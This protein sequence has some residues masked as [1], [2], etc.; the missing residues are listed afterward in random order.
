MNKINDFDEP[1]SVHLQ[2]DELFQTM[3]KDS[4]YE[5]GNIM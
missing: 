2:G 4:Y 1:S 5:D 3:D